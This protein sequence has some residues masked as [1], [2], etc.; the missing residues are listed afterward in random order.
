MGAAASP[1]GDHPIAGRE[2]LFDLPVA[3]HA[4]LV[5]GDDLG[6]RLRAT[7][8]GHLRIV[9]PVPGGEHLAGDL[10]LALVAHLLV[11]ATNHCLISC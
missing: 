11:E 6:H 8:A 4:L 9:Q 10:V 1:T 2:D 5:G 7:A 3:V